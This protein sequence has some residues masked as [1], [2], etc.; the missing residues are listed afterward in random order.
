MN[1]TTHKTPDCDGKVISIGTLVKPRLVKCTKCRASWEA[2]P[3]TEDEQPSVEDAD[4]ERMIRDASSEGFRLGLWRTAV[5]VWCA[6]AVGLMI[7]IWIGYNVERGVL[8]L[9]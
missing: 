8:S 7:G 1:T 9:P 5:L 4:V 6:L 3:V 2:E